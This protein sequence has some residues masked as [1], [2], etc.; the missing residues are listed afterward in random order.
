MNDLKKEII[1]KLNNVIVQCS[2]DDAFYLLG[3]VIE[4]AMRL[5]D[6]CDII[7]HFNDEQ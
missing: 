2:S 7:R 1:D 6:Q 5:Q 3:E 4:E